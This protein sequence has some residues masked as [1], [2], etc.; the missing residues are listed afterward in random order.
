MTY[1]TIIV[2]VDESRHLYRRAELAARVAAHD[3][4]HLIGIALTGVPGFVRDALVL[5]PGDPFIDPLLQRPRERAADAL[6]IFENIAR[7]LHAGTVETRLENDDVGGFIVQARC[8][9]LV[10]LGQ[11][12]PFE[13][14]LATMPDFA[15]TVIMESGMPV[16]MVPCNT[17]G[18][19]EL[20]QVLIAW[21]ASKEA[22]R[23]VHRALPMLRRAARVDV[24]IFNP[25][26]IPTGNHAA[27]DQDIVVWL[28]RQGIKTRVT[29]QAATGEIDIG[30]ALLSLAGD[31]GADL[32]V[33]GCYGHARFREL[34]LG[35]V[36]R[37][38]LAEMNLPVLMAH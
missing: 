13:V 2:H 18:G 5:N 23:A 34:L 33:M 12:D 8:S 15:Q 14:G 35:G 17:P 36:S 38:I 11:Y 27:P 25:D 3:N 30:K 22:T 26:A 32:L 28:A 4:A 31:L 16:L 20:A 1:K 37:E 6:S 10:V 21:N 7:Q 19:D 24:A 29:H 9:D